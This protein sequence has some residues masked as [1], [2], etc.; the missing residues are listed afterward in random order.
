M[1]PVTF[2]SLVTRHLS[3]FVSSGVDDR[4]AAEALRNQELLISEADLPEPD[5]DEV[6]LNDII[7]LN[8]LCA[9]QSI[10]VIDHVLFPAGQELWSILGSDGAEILFPAVPEFV[11]DIDL[12]AGTVT[13]NPPEGLLEINT[14]AAKPG[15]LSQA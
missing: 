14:S 3:F 15:T 9:G 6:Y 13:I 4:T 12:D 5:D 10:G 8:V 11:E 7:G 1:S 2:L